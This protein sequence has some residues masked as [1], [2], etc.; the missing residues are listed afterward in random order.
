MVSCSLAKAYKDGISSYKHSTSPQLHM[1][2]YTTSRLSSEKCNMRSF[3]KSSCKIPLW[4]TTFMMLMNAH[5][6]FTQLC[7]KVTSCLHPSILDVRM[8]KWMFLLNV[9]CMLPINNLFWVSFSPTQ[10]C[11]GCDQTFEC[12]PYAPHHNHLDYP[13]STKGTHLLCLES[14]RHLDFLFGKEDFEPFFHPWCQLC[15]FLINSY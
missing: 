9:A 7:L 11:L 5:A 4:C 6:I 14:I 8:G 1:P 15:L 2:M 10:W 3:N 12:T 13:Y